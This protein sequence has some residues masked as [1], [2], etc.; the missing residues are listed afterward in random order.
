MKKQFKKKTKINNL[1]K[2]TSLKHFDISGNK[3]ES[4]PL[5]IENL[6]NLTYLNISFNQITSIP[7]Q[8]GFFFFFFL[9]FLE[10]IIISFI[11]KLISLE[12]L[13]ISNN[14][15]KTIPLEITNLIN[16]TEF[17]FSFNQISS[18]LNKIGLHFIFFFSL[19]ENLFFF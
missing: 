8:I 6:I 1:E 11:G 4:I 9:T 10:F 12:H 19:K 5:E 15:I 14:E 17:N 16:I 2:L 7:K 13:D 18:I 3:I